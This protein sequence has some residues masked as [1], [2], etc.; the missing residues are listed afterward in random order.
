[1]EEVI[2]DE[3]TISQITEMGNYL[4][5]FSQVPLDIQTTLHESHVAVYSGCIFFYMF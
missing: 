4:D 2:G 5:S 1:M 3:E